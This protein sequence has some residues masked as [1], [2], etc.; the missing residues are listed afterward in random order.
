MG[1]RQINHP[2]T[3]IKV[4]RPVILGVNLIHRAA[5]LADLIVGAVV[6]T[7][8]ALIVGCQ[9][10][11]LTLHSVKAAEAAAQRPHS[12]PTCHGP[13]LPAPEVEDLLQRH[14]DQTLQRC[15][16]QRTPHLSTLMTTLS[17]HQ[18]ICASKM[19]GRKKTKRWPLLQNLLPQPLHHNRNQDLAF[20]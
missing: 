4:I 19:R 17:A 2:T 1:I 3:K 13:Q 11:V 9:A 14:L 20:L 8:T 7:T 12:S 15:K 6:I 16:Q 18:K 10:L 5:I